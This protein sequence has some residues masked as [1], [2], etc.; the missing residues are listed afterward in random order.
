VHNQEINEY[1][2]DF[3]A[4]FLRVS[5]WI[6]AMRGQ[7]GKRLIIR[8]VDQQSPA[9]MW[10]ILRY[11]LRRFPAF[12]VDGVERVAGWEGD[13]D[14]AVNRALSRRAVIVSGSPQP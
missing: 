1:P 9:G 13:P 5:G 12:L 14:G 11:R 2:E 6:R 8:L 3:K 4:E 10:K 7:Y